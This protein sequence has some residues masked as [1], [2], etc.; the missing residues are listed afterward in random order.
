MAE[1]THTTASKH[2]SENI[3]TEKERDEKHYH[4]IK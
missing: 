1:G 2:I 4:I 3:F